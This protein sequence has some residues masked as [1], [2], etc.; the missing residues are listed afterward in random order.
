M[1]DK[2]MFKLDDLFS[3]AGEFY[4][5]NP[6][7]EFTPSLVVFKQD[8]TDMIRFPDFNENRFSILRTFGYSYAVTQENVLGVVFM[9]EFWIRSDEDNFSAKQEAFILLAKTIDHQFTAM[10]AEIDRGNGK[11]TII[12]DN[13]LDKLEDNLLSEF[14][15]GYKL[16]KQTFSAQVN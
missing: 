8:T 11:L 10:V 16:G 3:F 5:A 6:D 9:G 4:K 1:I 13:T 15:V 14:F 7:S 12:E 2:D